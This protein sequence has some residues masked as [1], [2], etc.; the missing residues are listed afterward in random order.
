MAKGSN[1]CFISLPNFSFSFQLSCYSE[2]L[3]D[4][5]KDERRGEIKTV[6]DSWKIETHIW[7]IHFSSY[8]RTS[9]SEHIVATLMPF[10]RYDH[11]E[12]NCSGFLSWPRKEALELFQQF[13]SKTDGKVL[14]FSLVPLGQRGRGGR[15]GS[16]GCRDGSN[17]GQTPLPTLVH[18]LPQPWQVFVTQNSKSLFRNFDSIWEKIRYLHCKF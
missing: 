10:F 11:Q 5:Q 1:F 15:W 12:G 4:K 8:K 9:G 13:G 16:P 17:K 7:S 6:I 14:L 2:K 18:G 3:K